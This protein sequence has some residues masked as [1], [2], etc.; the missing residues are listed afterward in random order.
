[1]HVCASCEVCAQLLWENSTRVLADFTPGAGG[2]V[3][4]ALMMYIKIIVVCHNAAQVRV[5]RDILRA[6]VLEDMQQSSSRFAPVDKKERL[7][8]CKPDRLKKHETQ[9]KRGNDDMQLESPAAKRTALG[10]CVESMLADLDSPSAQKS[11]AV[12]KAKAAAAAAAAA[13]AAAATATTGASGNGST[14]GGQQQIAA[15]A[16][17]AA[18]AQASTSA[19]T[20]GAQ[21]VGSAGTAGAQ[22]SGSAGT[23]AKP[24]AAAPSG[25]RARGRPSGPSGSVGRLMTD[26]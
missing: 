13:K 22:A 11:P 21:A 9:K 25:R 6:F 18:G 10:E 7:E 4:A 5:L 17:G 23:G 2:I 26:D 1:M 20:A 15:A 12:A 3:K 19:G 14:S 24:K 8:A 16:E